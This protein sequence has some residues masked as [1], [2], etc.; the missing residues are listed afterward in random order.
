MRSGFAK[1]GALRNTDDRAFRAIRDREP[2]FAFSMPLKLTQSGNSSSSGS[3]SVTFTIAH[4]Q[5][6]VVQFASARGLTMMRPLWMAWFADAGELLAFH[7]KDFANANALASNYSEQLAKDAY[8]S[9][10]DDYVDIVALSARQVLGATSF[11]GTAEDPILF[12]KEIS[13]NGNFQ[14]I[15]V[16]FPSFPFFLYT[17]PRWLAY[18]LE[19]LIEHMLSGQYPNTY[20]MHDLGSHFPNATGHPDGRDEYMPVEECG[21]ILI[22]GLAVANSLLYASDDEAASIWS[23]RGSAAAMPSG[24]SRLF[25]L[26]DHYSDGSAGIGHQDAKWGGGHLGQKLAEQWVQRSYKLWTQWTGYLV[27]FSLEP[28]NQREEL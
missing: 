20:A 15:D 10:A 9:G 5:D 19:P 16:I 14:T 13:S 1:K 24:S 7:Y 25:S 6:P 2:V 18:L 12:L 4:I 26:A 21:N 22:M 27:E 8:M 23:A 17:N 3:G 11:S 28:A